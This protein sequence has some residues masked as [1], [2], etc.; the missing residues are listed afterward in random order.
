MILS[1]KYG[2]DEAKIKALVRDGV[3]PCS[4]VRHSEI[5]SYY[6]SKLGSGLKKSDAVHATSDD[7]KISETLVYRII[8]RFS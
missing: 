1:T 3:I 2:I 7:L 8:Q 4:V 5:M 6:I